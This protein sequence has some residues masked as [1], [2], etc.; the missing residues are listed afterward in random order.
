MQVNHITYQKGI[1]IQDT[2]GSDGL[3][4]AQFV[5][6]C[7]VGV[8]PITLIRVIEPINVMTCFLLLG[9][10]LKSL[11]QLR[12]GILICHYRVLSVCACVCQRCY[13]DCLGQASCES[14]LG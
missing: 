11:L 14:M 1:V 5:I 2:R 9:E 4:F 10:R 12:V 7:K 13:C 8:I 6:M 3:Q